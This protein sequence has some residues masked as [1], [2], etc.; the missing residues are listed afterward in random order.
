MPHYYFDLIDGF[1]RKDRKGLDCA[2][3][4]AAIITGHVISREVAAAASD[5]SG[6]DLH[7]SVVNEA[8]SEVLQIPVI[9]PFSPSSS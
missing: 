1:T 7:I 6:P 5:H 9:W 3:D 4:A 2:N 8:G